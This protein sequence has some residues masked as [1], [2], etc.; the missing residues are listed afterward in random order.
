MSV[1]AASE[2]SIARFGR[3]R[4]MTIPIEEMAMA[5]TEAVR[6]PSRSCRRR[7]GGELDSGG[8]VYSTTGARQFGSD[9]PAHRRAFGVRRKR[10][11]A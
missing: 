7:E 4:C 6:R 1:R 9:L 2:A 5:A 11:P 10:G 8:G 3:R